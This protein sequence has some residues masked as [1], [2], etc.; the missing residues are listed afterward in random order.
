MAESGRD[1][2]L[3]WR[4]LASQ[5]QSSLRE[6]ERKRETERETHTEEL[7]QLF[8]DLSG[9]GLQQS[10]CWQSYSKLQVCTQFSPV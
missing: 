2:T 10:T 3:L 9:R 4:S 1:T 7:W 5:E 6:R 8:F